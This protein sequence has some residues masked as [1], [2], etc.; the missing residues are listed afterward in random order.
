MILLSQVWPSL[1][2]EPSS[3]IDVVDDESLLNL[4]SLKG[5]EQQADVTRLLEEFQCIFSDMPETTHLAEHKI[6]FMTK[7]SIRVR[8]Y[9]IPHAKRQEVEKKSRLC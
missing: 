1:E 4:V 2:A 9:Q 6:E 3:E 8:P 7:S 5:E